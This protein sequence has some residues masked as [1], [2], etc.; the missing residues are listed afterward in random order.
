[1]R[2]NTRQFLALRSIAKEPWHLSSRRVLWRFNGRW[3]YLYS[4]GTRE[5]LS[6]VRER[7]HEQRDGDFDLYDGAERAAWD[8]TFMGLVDYITVR[9]SP[10]TECHLNDRAAFQLTARGASLLAKANESSRRRVPPALADLPSTSSPWW[11]RWLTLRPL[12]LSSRL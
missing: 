8:L 11:C 6:S 1:M 9:C 4:D 5:K 2:L 10:G 12:R 7:G 3:H